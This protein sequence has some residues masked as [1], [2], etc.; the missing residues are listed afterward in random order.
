MERSP[1][2]LI[3]ARGTGLPLL[4]DFLHHRQFNFKGT[5]AFKSLPDMLL[6]WDKTQ[7]RILYRNKKNLR[8]ITRRKFSRPELTS[9][10]FSWTRLSITRWKLTQL[11][12]SLLKLRRITGL[13]I[14]TTTSF[15]LGKKHECLAQKEARVW[16]AEIE[17]I[18]ACSEPSLTHYK[19]LFLLFAFSARTLWSTSK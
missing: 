4:S 12:P 18:K 7:L 3:C 9:Y 2:S 11:F 10:H 17:S 1:K 5:A 14:N 13:S 16:L 6:L 15:L 19:E 8:L